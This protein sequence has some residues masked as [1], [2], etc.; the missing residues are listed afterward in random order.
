MECRNIPAMQNKIT[1]PTFLGLLAALFLT[2]CTATQQ[3]ERSDN[4]IQ[5]VDRN[6]AD[7]A[8]VKT[9]TLDLIEKTVKE[10]ILVVF[11]IDNTLLAMEQGL[12]SDQWY[13]WQK[14]LSQ[15]DRCSP[16]NVG[17]R[18]AVQGAMYFASATRRTQ[19]D[20]AAQVKAIQDMGV[21]VI[22]LTSRGPDYQLATF[23]ELRRNNFNFSYSALGPE[24]GYEKPFIP[25]ENGR[26]SLYE[27]GVFLTA[28]QHKGEMLFALLNK[29]G[30]RLPAVIVM[31][32]DKQKN[33]DAVKETFSALNVP[34]HAWRYTAE[35][36]AVSNFDPDTANAQWKSIE[37]ALRQVQQ[38]LG[39]DNYDLSSA[40]KPPECDQPLSSPPV[41]GD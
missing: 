35:D 15:E 1:T 8:D 20:G 2:A 18:F 29:T 31:V 11:D 16:L 26:L 23:R 33:L 12:G 13:E 28:G 24:G 34:V 39:P 5:A 30:T 19:A 7:L 14:E 36:Q 10:N 4:A 9:D 41:S 6:T 40:V 17:D 3:T 27:D 38:V 21:A 25:V 37:D 32:D 22:S